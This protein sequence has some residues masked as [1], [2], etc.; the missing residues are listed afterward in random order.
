M[1]MTLSNNPTLEEIETYLKRAE[2]IL[3]VMR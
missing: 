1:N 3:A 2:E